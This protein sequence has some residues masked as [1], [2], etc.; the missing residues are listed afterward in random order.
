MKG[1]INMISF[2]IAKGTVI[3]SLLYVV[4][5]ELSGIIPALKNNGVLGSILK[6]LK[7]IGAKYPLADEKMAKDIMAIKD[8]SSVDSPKV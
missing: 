7:G 4:L 6:A 3:L 8:E 5:N 1:V 2:I